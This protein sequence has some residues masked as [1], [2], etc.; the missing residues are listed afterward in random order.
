M[1]HFRITPDSRLDNQHVETLAQTLCYQRSLIERWNGRTIDR[2]PW[3][4]FE[5]VLRRKGA[6]FY[7]TV[8]DDLAAFVPKAVTSTWP[9]A[10][11]EPTADP[12]SDLPSAP[13]ATAT[14]S[15]HY[16]YM[17][18][19]RV[20]RRENRLLQA[21]LDV[22]TALEDGDALVAQVLGVPAPSDWY[23]AASEAYE[24][25]RRGEMP[26][27]LALDRRRLGRSALRVATAGVLEVI[28]IITELMTGEEPKPIR[29]DEA[30]RAAILRDGRL[31][32]E[33]LAK[34][35]GD[36]YDTTIRVAVFADQRRAPALLRMATMAFRELDGDNY[37]DVIPTKPERIWRKMR[38]RRNDVKLQRDYL[39]IPEFARLLLL[40]TGP[41]QERYGLERI[42][43]LEVEVPAIL[44]RGG[45]YLGV[46]PYKGTETPV[47]QPTDNW[48]ELCLP[49][50]VI[51]GMGQGKTRGFG[52]NWV[53]EAVRNGFG[54]LVIDP[55]KGEIGDEVSTVLPPSKV[56][57]IR[58]DRTPFALDFCEVRRAPRAKNRL[59]NAILSFFAASGDDAG[60]QTARY[61]RAAVMAMRTGRLSEILRILEEDEYRAKVLESLPEGMHRSTL[62]SLGEESPARRRQILGPIYN[63]LDTILGDTYLTECLNSRRSLDMV[64]LMS[65]KHAVII[66]VP[67][68]T[69]GAEVVDLVAN[70]LSVKI[71]LA[72]TFRPERDQFPFFVIFDEPHQFLRSARIWKSA[73]IESRKW[74]VG[75]V[76]MFHSWEQ[77]PRDLAE[78][79]KAAGPHYHLYPSSKRTFL[80]LREEIAPFTIEDG[81]KLQRWH[82]INVLRVGGEV[83]RPFIAK[84]APPPSKRTSA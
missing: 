2:H 4:S 56:V 11:V 29:L 24:R 31:R 55:A 69:L 58:L 3:V 34:P 57:R 8:H 80:D 66:D 79:I 30:D 32:P 35:R 44:R 7:L 28:G 22:M 17:F 43:Y 47:Y 1:K 78:I 63:R 41:I 70:L 12:L 84:M 36:A 40:P 14:L 16:H 21:L 74:R 33:T 54:A 27:K 5:I 73:A 61:L 48:D 81:L 9:R 76:W 10:C 67:K 75:Y 23:V 60:V 51:G 64:D 65:K 20:D 42:Q 77:I 53:V 26:G 45:I 71:D 13:S 38:E 72:M 50:V 82:A 25:F 46:A 39:S 37:F 68:A 6:G 49:H 19:I 52:A 83:Q 62:E 18:A 59:A 15:L